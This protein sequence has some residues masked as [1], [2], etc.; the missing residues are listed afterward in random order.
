MDSGQ[1]TEVHKKVVFTPTIS[2]LLPCP[3]PSLVY[4]LFFGLQT[5]HLFMLSHP[6][7]PPSEMP[8]GKEH[9]KR[10]YA[11]AEYGFCPRGTGE[12]RLNILSVYVG[13]NVS[14]CRR[15][16]GQEVFPN[17]LLK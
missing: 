2:F 9:Y 7:F 15:D 4:I 3:L 5:L 13:W 12:K 14:G 8:L 17:S 1:D 11:K 10:I 6:T 16:L